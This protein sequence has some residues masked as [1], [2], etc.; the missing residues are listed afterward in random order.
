MA[1][2]T[3]EVSSSLSSTWKMHDGM[4][5]WCGARPLNAEPHPHCL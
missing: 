2:L 3:L 5:P 4:R 1:L